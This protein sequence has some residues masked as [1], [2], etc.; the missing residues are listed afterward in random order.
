ME[1]TFEAELPPDLARLRMLRRALAE[2]LAEADVDARA[3]EAIV[4][5]THE[6]AAN[7]MQH[8]DACVLVTV[9]RDP[10]GVRVVVRSGGRWKRFDG[11]ELRGRGLP[12]MHGLMSEVEIA[13]GDGRSVVDMRLT[14]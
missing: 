10:G 8:A 1:S 14:L 3:A 11:G 5:A 2:W 12:I 7:A 13:S 9:S 4:L 6:A